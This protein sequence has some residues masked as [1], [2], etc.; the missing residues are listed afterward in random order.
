MPKA[1]PSRCV[2]RCGRFAT[3]QGR[4]E[5][6]QR[7]PWEQTSKRNEIIDQAKWL[8]VRRWVR[9]EEK[10]CRHC[11]SR[12]RLEVDHII[13]VADGGAMYERAN[14]QVLCADCHQ[15]KTLRARQMRAAM[16]DST[17]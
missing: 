3:H 8:K 9:A 17:R 1:A 6:H 14:I 16:R 15:K 11:G 12:T 10:S 13:E 7:K 4:C 2:M 5:E